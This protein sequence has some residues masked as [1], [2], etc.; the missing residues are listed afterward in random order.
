MTGPL[1]RLLAGDD[2]PED[3]EIAELAFVTPA[4]SDARL[5]T[6]RYSVETRVNHGD[7]PSSVALDVQPTDLLPRTHTVFLQRYPHPREDPLQP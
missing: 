3:L 1:L 7:D 5:L 4:S 2:D 6:W